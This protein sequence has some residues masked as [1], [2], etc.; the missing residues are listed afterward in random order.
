MT[1]IEAKDNAHGVGDGIQQ[2]LVYAALGLNSGAKSLPLKWL[3]SLAE[4]M[5]SL[6][7][8]KR[9]NSETCSGRIPW[10]Q[11]S[12]SICLWASF[13]IFMGT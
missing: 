6:M 8:R 9:T 7:K 5:L 3:K 11:K 4:P 12:L 1:L 10:N 2:D 13:K